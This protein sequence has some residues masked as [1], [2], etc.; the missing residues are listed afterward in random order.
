MCII[1][2]NSLLTLDIVMYFMLNILYNLNIN[3]F[4]KNKMYKIN[5]QLIF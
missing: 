3:L 5:N 2:L 1:N 4:K